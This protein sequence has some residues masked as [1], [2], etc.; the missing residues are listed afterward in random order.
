[1][2]NLNLLIME[3]NV[4]LVIVT[5]AAGVWEVV[6]RAVPTVNNWAGTAVVLKVLNFL[7]DLL[8]NKKKEK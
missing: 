6:A 1:M 7:S 3:N 5:V 8:N 2:L 4:L